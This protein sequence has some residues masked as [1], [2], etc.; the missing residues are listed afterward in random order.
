MILLPGL[1]VGALVDCQGLGFG[2][3]RSLAGPGHVICPTSLPVVSFALIPRAVLSLSV[4]WRCPPA[5]LVPTCV[6][7]SAAMCCYPSAGRWEGRWS[8]YHMSPLLVDLPS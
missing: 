3:C 2:I 6:S 1:W 4:G 8:L 7:S 5:L